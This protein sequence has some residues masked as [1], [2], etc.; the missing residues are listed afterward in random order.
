MV[1]NPLGGG[2]MAILAQAI[3]VL[4]YAVFVWAIFPKR[5]TKG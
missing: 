5:R 3:G 2:I 1:K 4:G